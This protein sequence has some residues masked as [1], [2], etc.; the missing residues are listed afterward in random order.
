MPAREPVNLHEFEALARERLSEMAYEYAA[1]GV[2][3]EVTLRRNREAWDAL[4]LVPRLLRDVSAIDTRLE[5]PG[6]SLAFP[7]LVAPT[8]YQRLFHPEGECEAARGVAAAGAL[9][10]VSSVSNTPLDVIAAASGGPKWYQLYVQR[11]RGWTLEMIRRAEA[12]GYLGLVFTADTPVL[13]ARD[14]ER[15]V[16]FAPPPGITMPNFPPLPGGYGAEQHH[17][18]DSI[19]NPFLDPGMTWET[20][21]W[22]CSAS[23]LPVIVKGVLAPEDAVLAA[24]HGAAAVIVSNHGGRLL[25]GAP[26][27]ATALPRVADAVAGRIPLL[28]DGGI[29]RGSDV[30]KALA[31]GARATL[32]GRPFVWGLAAGGAD[33]VARVLRMLRLEFEAAMALAG[34]RSL[35]EITR[36][37]LG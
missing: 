26:A 25:D 9:Y 16:S 6:V 7:V 19:Y 36:A 29:R 13:G 28:V 21:D 8:G 18:P 2:G 12:A 35:A 34:A 24:D 37:L 4:T 11:D 22:L 23:K 1:G 20:V 17:V 5:L 14:R 27:T 33:G 3:D 15:R 30:L 10:C 32:I 31:L